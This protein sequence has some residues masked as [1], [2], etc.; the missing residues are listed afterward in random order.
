MTKG[1]G[2]PR[3]SDTDPIRV[4]FVDPAAHR[5]PGR[6][7]LTFAPGKCG[8][9]VYAAWDRD[10]TKDLVR[11]RTEYGTKVLVTLIEEFEMKAV[12]IPNLRDAAE[13]AGMRSLWFPIT[14]G[15]T[16]P[17]PGAPIPL[18]REVCD[19]LA[20]GDTV[21]IHCMGG[22]GRAGTIAAC[23]LVARGVA[24]SRAVELVREARPGAVENRAQV[25]FVR[26]FRD[27][28]QDR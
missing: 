14:D 24:P 26:R 25:T 15:W 11:L 23:V 12:G 28:L 17:T 22:L 16:P 9:G 19:H 1:P 7:G 3:T 20:N 4:D 13:R 8:R 21:V 6:L 27:A 5:L 18:V 10:L 2:V